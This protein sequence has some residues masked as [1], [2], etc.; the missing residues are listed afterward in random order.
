[1]HATLIDTYVRGHEHF[2]TPLS[3]YETERFYAEYRGLGRLIGVRER[4]L[5]ATWPQFCT[6]VRRTARTKLTRTPSVERVV[7]TVAHVGAPPAPIAGRLW[8]AIRFPVRRALWLGGIGLLEPAVRRRLGL[9]WTA[10]D[11][12]Q[13]R[14][15]AV[16]FRGLGPVLPASWKVTGPGHLRWRSVEIETGPL[17][18]AA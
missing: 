14:V 4:D 11:E 10:I 13:F 1:V 2:G 12:A 16:V 6:Y 15:L 3:R 17:G 5:P 8:P 9:G 18:R 7:N